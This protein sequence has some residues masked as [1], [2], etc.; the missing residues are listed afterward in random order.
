MRSLKSQP[1]IKMQHIIKNNS[2]RQSW[3]DTTWPKKTEALKTSPVRL[4][5]SLLVD[6]F[7]KMPKSLFLPQ[8]AV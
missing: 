1:N 6:R 8:K 3:E 7:P 2:S 5:F 4:S